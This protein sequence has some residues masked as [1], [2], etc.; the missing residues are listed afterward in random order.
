MSPFYLLHYLFLRKKPKQ[1]QSQGVRNFFSLNHN[2]TS[3]CCRGQDQSK[4]LLKSPILRSS[5][6]NLSFIN[7]DVLKKEIKVDVWPLLA[8]FGNIKSRKFSLLH[9]WTQGQY[10][11][12]IVKL[13]YIYSSEVSPL[14]GRLKRTWISEVSQ[15]HCFLSAWPSEKASSEYFPSLLEAANWGALHGIHLQTAQCLA[16]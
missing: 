3:I 10:C 12:E 7:K 6:H 4:I 14:W 8:R 2:I 1:I 11:W 15:I 5:I 9:P 13:L 16:P